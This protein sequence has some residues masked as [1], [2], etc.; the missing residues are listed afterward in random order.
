MIETNKINKNKGLVNN[1]EKTEKLLWKRPNIIYILFLISEKKI[2]KRLKN[3]K[4]IKSFLFKKRNE[5]IKLHT[6]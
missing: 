5:T 6:N 3:I 1:N 2:L 4:I